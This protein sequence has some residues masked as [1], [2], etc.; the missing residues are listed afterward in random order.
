M[1]GKALIPLNLNIPTD[2][3][4][5]NGGYGLWGWGDLPHRFS[6]KLKLLQLASIICQPEN[7]LPLEMF[8]MKR[9]AEALLKGAIEHTSPIHNRY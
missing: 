8:C 1:A 3:S 9:T 5:V 6:P 2:I 4:S 7:Y